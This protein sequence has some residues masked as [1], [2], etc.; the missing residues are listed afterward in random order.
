MTNWIK[1]SERM[2]EL[3]DNGYSKMVFVVGRKKIVQQ[4]FL[5]DGN[6]VFLM[7]VTHWMPIPELPED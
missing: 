2:S 4:N 6:W 3:D 1:C 5:K 7:D